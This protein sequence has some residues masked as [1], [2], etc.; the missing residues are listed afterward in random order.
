V[1]FYEYTFLFR[2]LWHAPSWKDKLVVLFGRPGETFEAPPK[3]AAPT[4]TA[5]PDLAAAPVAA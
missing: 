1:L 4:K 5:L 2:D 3:D